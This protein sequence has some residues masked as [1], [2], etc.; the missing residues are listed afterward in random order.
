MKLKHKIGRPG[1]NSSPNLQKAEYRTNIHPSTNRFTG[2][3][4]NLADYKYDVDAY[5]A[6][7]DRQISEMTPEQIEN[8]QYNDTIFTEPTQWNPN[9]VIQGGS[10]YYPGTKNIRAVDQPTYT[11]GTISRDANYEVVNP[12]DPSLNRAPGESTAVVNIPEVLDFVKGKQ[13]TL[14][15][16]VKP[17]FTRLD[18]ATDSEGNKLSIPRYN[19][20]VR[21]YERQLA[22]QQEY[23]A[24]TQRLIAKNQ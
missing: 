4:S 7:R 23:D 19:Q 9:K 3:D 2:Y 5:K 16:P 11:Q 22:A 12:V 1:Y 21:D 24:E 10:Y 17:A 13:K 6:D 8:L 18:A 15:T 20:Q 14:F